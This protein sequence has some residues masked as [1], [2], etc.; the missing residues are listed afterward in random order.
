MRD[1]PTIRSVMTT[2]PHFVEVDD[3]LARARELMV[4][5]QIRHLPV[6]D[7]GELVGVLT[8]RDLKRA[9]ELDDVR[10]STRKVLV[11]DVFVPEAYVVDGGERLDAVLEHMATH[12][13]GSALVTKGKKLAGILTSSDACRLFCEYLRSRS[14]RGPGD[15]VA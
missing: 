3:G 6:Q 8:D 2:F 12:H 9:S 4:E 5:H 10:P 13:I 11:G 14:P 7:H 1:V 15:D